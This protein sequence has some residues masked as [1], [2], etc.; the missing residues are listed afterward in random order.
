[1]ASHRASAANGTHTGPEKSYYEQQRELL[2]TEIAQVRPVIPRIHAHGFRKTQ[3]LSFWQFP[4][5]IVPSEPGNR[6]SEYQQAKSLSRGSHP[7]RQRIR[8]RGVAMEP[9]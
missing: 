9:L 8:A 7:S 4:V 5:L 3:R 6:A 2:V 1:M